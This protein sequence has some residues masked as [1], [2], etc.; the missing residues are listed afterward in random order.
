VTAVL[1]CDE[2]EKAAEFLDTGLNAYYRDFTK[3]LCGGFDAP[4]ELLVESATFDE[5]LERAG[6]KSQICSEPF[7]ANFNVPPHIYLSCHGSHFDVTQSVL[8]GAQ[9]L[10]FSSRH[11]FM[12]PTAHGMFSRFHQ[13]LLAAIAED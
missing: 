3:G 12:N 7:P 10:V 2:L 4:V 8:V 9:Y 5:F 6:A 1:T 11:V 13:H